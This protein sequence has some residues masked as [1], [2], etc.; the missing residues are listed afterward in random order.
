MAAGRQANFKCAENMVL[1]SEL[2]SC[3]SEDRATLSP[4]NKKIVSIIFKFTFDPATK[5]FVK[6]KE[7]SLGTK[8]YFWEMT[9]VK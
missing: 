7:Q 3:S 5:H 8:I 6:D 4:I 2:G 1:T 9:L